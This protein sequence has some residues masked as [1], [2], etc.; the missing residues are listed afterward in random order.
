M[1]FEAFFDAP[2][3]DYNSNRQLF[4]DNMDM[5]R[6]MT[7]EEHT[8]YK[9]WKEVQGFSRFIDK[10]SVVKAKIW[11]PTDIFQR[12]QT[13]SELEALEP[14]VVFVSSDDKQ[15][16]EEWLIL[17]IFIHTM[18]FEQ[19]PGRFLRFIIRDA[20]THKYLGIASIGSDVISISCRDQWIGWDDNSKIKE[21]KLRNTAIATTIVPVQP[22]GFNFLGGKLIASMLCL[23]PVRQAWEDTYGDKLVGLTTTSLFGKHSMYQRIP[24]WKELGETMGKIMLKPDD[25][26]YDIWH[27]WIKENKPDE[28]EKKTVGGPGEGPATGVKQKILV[29]IM[30]ELGVKQS[31]Y[32]H[33]FRRGVYYSPFYSNTREFLRSEVSENSLVPLDKLSYSE[34]MKWWKAKAARRYVNLLESNRLN[35]DILYYNRMIGMSWDDATSTYLKEVGR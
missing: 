32:M 25:S 27:H 7:N 13:I 14:E 34:V 22:L 12:N 23:P 9:K 6:A 33:G 3:A 2:V 30:Q 35:P 28:Y 16:M 29:M 26:V 21:G 20:N 8:L 24:F 31:Q 10:S 19:N 17:R 5:L 15:L 4:V 11:E 1:G 18:E